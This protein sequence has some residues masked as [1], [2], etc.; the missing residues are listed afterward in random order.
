MSGLSS[1][2]NVYQGDGLIVERDGKVI[3]K[4]TGDSVYVYTSNLVL[5]S[6]GAKVTELKAPGDVDL[7]EGDILIHKGDIIIKGNSHVSTDLNI[8][9]NVKIQGNLEMQGSIMTLGG[10]TNWGDLKS[11][12]DVPPVPPAPE[13][14]DIPSLPAD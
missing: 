2:Y 5:V 11:A 8:R 4:V 1:V 7:Y 12:A 9:G 3:V 13:W 10:I 14:T 6:G